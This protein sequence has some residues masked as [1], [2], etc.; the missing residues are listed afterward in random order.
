MSSQNSPT[1][2]RL[3]EHRRSFQLARKTGPLL[4]IE[5]LDAAEMKIFNDEFLSRCRTISPDDLA[6]IYRVYVEALHRWGIMCPHP[7]A[8]RLYSG[9]IASDVPLGFSEERWYDCNL[10]GSAV[11]NR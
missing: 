8:H 10:C 7:Q 3:E 5:E 4:R 6:E 9:W 11:I 2:T 1:E